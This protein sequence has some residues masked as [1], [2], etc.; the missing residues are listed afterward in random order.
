MYN[1][2]ELGSVSR[3]HEN[4]TNLSIRLLQPLL[5]IGIVS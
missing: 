5:S 3:R 1:M 2:Q 4:C